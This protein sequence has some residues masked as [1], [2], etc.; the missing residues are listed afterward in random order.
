[1]EENFEPKRRVGICNKCAKK[2]RFSGAGRIRFIPEGI[3]DH[4]KD[5]LKEDVGV[6]IS[7][8]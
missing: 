3:N 6:R 1:M 5:F 4:Q 2:F 8:P 7:M